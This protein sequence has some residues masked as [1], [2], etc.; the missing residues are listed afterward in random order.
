MI[1]LKGPDHAGETIAD[2]SHESLIPKWKNLDIGWLWRRKPSE[3][4]RR[5]RT[6][7]R[8]LGWVR[9]CGG[10]N[11]QALAYTDAERGIWNEAWAA[12]LKASGSYQ[13][14]C[15]FLNR[16]QAD[17]ENEEW[18][19]KRLTLAAIILLFATLALGSIAGFYKYR[20]V[21]P[22]KARAESDRAR[23]ELLSNEGKL[24]QQI[25][26]SDELLQQS[27]QR[28][29]DL[30]AQIGRAGQS[31]EA[32]SELE[33]LRRQIIQI[34]AQRNGAEASLSTESKNGTKVN[35]VDGLPYVYVPS[36]NFMMGCSPDDGECRINEKMPPHSEQI[37]NG[38][39][40]GQ[41]EV[42]QA[43]WKKVRGEKNPSHFT[44][45]QLPVE[46]VDWTQAGDYCKIIGGRLP[47][48]KEWEYAARAR[49]AGS[50]YGS[51]DA[52]AWYVGNSSGTTHPVGL[53]EANAFGLFDMLGNV[54]EWTSDDDGTGTGDKTARGGSWYN[55]TRGVR[56]SVRAGSVLSGWDSGMGS[57]AWGNSVKRP[58]SSTTT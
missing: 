7:S 5:P 56:A 55:N 15:D 16:Q 23:L 11:E 48:E 26:A 29:R 42:T 46:N 18:R 32:R 41:T 17:Q 4:I 27:A 21:A 1:S 49:T 12:R 57:V 28:A 9:G 2:I 30:E 53:K 8:I 22:E 51:L 44:S 38:F 50:R 58:E 14:V 31:P 37:P 52:V 6:T 54:W 36:G 40:L 34:Q 13:Q 24:R 43:A 25:A 3:C 10:G 33:K 39:W 45:D 19:K 47:T 35:L 20:Q